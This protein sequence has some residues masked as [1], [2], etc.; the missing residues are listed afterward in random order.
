MLGLVAQM[1]QQQSQ[2]ESIRASLKNGER[3]DAESIPD[4]DAILNQPV[5]LSPSQEAS[6]KK[7]VVE[8]EATRAQ[9]ARVTTDRDHWRE[10]AQRHEASLDTLRSD[11]NARIDHLIEDIKTL[12]EEKGAQYS[13]GFVDGMKAAHT[14]KE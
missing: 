1:R 14:P 6:L 10:Q 12:S 13:K 5:S 7:L 2:F 3:A 4:P 11:L 9:L 8:L